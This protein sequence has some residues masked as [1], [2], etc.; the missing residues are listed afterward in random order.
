VKKPVFFVD[1]DNF[2]S[3]FLNSLVNDS[4][5]HPDLQGVGQ[6]Q[7]EYLSRLVSF[8]KEKKCV[9]PNVVCS[10]DE[11]HASLSRIIIADA[12]QG[13]PV[14]DAAPPAAIVD[15]ERRAIVST[16]ANCILK[17]QGR[18]VPETILL[19]CKYR[20]LELMKACHRKIK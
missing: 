3:Q 15:L 1:S 18:T 19:N 10:A 6:K 11:F 2:L 9:I 13:E 8:I 5:N 20:L 7:N 4:T 12:G 17:S 16:Y 14:A